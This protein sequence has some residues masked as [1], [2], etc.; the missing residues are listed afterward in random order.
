M[1]PAPPGGAVDV[2]ATLL[3]PALAARDAAR[4]AYRAG[5]LD[6]L[7]LVDAE[8]LATEAALV[9]TELEIEAVAT[10]ISARLAAGE[11]PLP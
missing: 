5:A 7:R 9:A 6:V 4:A 2:R 8:R 10:A 1:R 11:G 3:D